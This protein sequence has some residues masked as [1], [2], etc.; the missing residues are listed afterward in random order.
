MRYGMMGSPHSEVG[1]EASNWQLTFLHFVIPRVSQYG[2][3]R[4]VDTMTVIFLNYR[5]S[6][7]QSLIIPEDIVPL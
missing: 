7:L 5:C 1:E 4:A 2:R 6:R 3:S